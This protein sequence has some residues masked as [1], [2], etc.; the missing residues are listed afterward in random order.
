ML[1]KMELG[2]LQKG[3]GLMLLPSK[4]PESMRSI[5]IIYIKPLHIP[6]L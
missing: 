2:L 1:L 6:L 5:T 4:F 3:V